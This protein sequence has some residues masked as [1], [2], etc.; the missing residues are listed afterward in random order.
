MDSYCSLFHLHIYLYPVDI[1]MWDHFSKD[2]TSY[3]GRWLI[4]LPTQKYCILISEQL[5]CTDCIIWALLPKWLWVDSANG[6]HWQ[7]IRGQKKKQGRD[8]FPHSFPA[9]ASQFLKV[10]ACCII[11]APLSYHWSLAAQ[12]SHLSLLDCC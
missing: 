3:R 10:I 1:C 9:S 7:E 5:N 6:R 2:W 11:T 8:C 4:H 12:F